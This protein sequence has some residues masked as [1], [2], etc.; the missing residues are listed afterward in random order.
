MWLPL[1]SRSRGCALPLPQHGLG[2]RFDPGAR[3]VDQHPRRHH[4][5]LA[6]RI[7]DEPPGV[8]ALGALGAHAARA[9]ADH[10]AAFGGI[11]RV[12][13]DEARVVGEAVG[14]FV[15]VME[16][17]AQ[18]LAGLVGDQIEFARSRQNLAPA[19]P[20]VEQKA[21]P[22]QHRRA[23]RLVERQHETQRP[24]QVRRRPQQHFALAER[25][26]H[27]AKFAVLQIAQAAMD[28]LRG[29]RRR[30]R[31]QVVLL[32]QHD[33]QAAPGGIAGDA[34]PVDAAADHRQIEI[35]H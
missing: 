14:I 28:Q 4:V 12:E 35:S 13:H 1:S 6:A 2:D 30:A 17:A 10:R 7:E 19:D 18:R 33:A 23:P 11:H 27:Q 32:E 20:V 31:G 25:R 22:Q 3:R 8:F 34:G 9:G 26:A 24:D 5:A 29:R 16:T 15:G 21:E